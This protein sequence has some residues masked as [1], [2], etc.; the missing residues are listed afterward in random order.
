MIVVTKK[1]VKS[2]YPKRFDWSHKGD[3]GRLLVVGGSKQYTGSPLLTSLAAVKSG[4]DWVDLFSPKRAADISASISPDLIT[5]PQRGDFL[6]SWHLR[7]ALILKKSANAV[8]IGNG[9]GM[10]KET[11]SFV[12]E[13]LK[14][15]NEPCVVDADAINILSSKE[16]LIKKNFVLTPHSYEFFLLTDKQPTDNVSERMGM[17]QRYAKKLG[18]TILL[19]GN[20]D[21]ISDGN[22]I[23]TNK[24]GN[25]FMTKAGTGDVLAGICGSLLARGVKPFD[26]AAAAAWINGSAGDLTAKQYGEGFMSQLLLENISKVLK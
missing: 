23:I 10:R 11:Q 24:T 22:N 21:I 9:L 3:F 15:T 1:F 4:V 26:A 5:H 6:N 8:V 16:I 25:P 12:K 2:L 20:I 19:K 7:E 18:C 17:V 14:K 13:F